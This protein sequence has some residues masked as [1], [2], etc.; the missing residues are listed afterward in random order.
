[1]FTLDFF[2]IRRLPMLQAGHQNKIGCRPE[3]RVKRGEGPL[4][5]M[6][7]LSIDTTR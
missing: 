4:A 1:M 3:A 5:F 7:V 6:I 2:T